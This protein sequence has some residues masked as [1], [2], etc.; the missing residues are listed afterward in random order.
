MISLLPLG[1]L[2]V[3]KFTSSIAK[4]TQSKTKKHSF[5]KDTT[6]RM[7]FI[8]G[9]SSALMMENLRNNPSILDIK[10]K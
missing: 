3:M 1:V 10:K 5:S 6:N 2:Q 8:D 7:K 9:F 4:K